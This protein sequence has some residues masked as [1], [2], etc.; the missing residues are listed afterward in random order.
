MCVVSMVGDH[1][2]E[3]WRW[4]EPHIQPTITNIP[5]GNNPFVSKPDTF[6]W[7]TGVS[8]EEFQE[9]K[10]EV[11]EMKE[12]LKKAIRYDEIHNQ[13]ECE[14]EEKIELLKKVAELV[15]VDLKDIFKEKQ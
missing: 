9:L 2:S 1:Y 4:V 14:V 8:N 10:K 5:P 3:K 13:P 11:L 7:P 15:G 12:L 6:R